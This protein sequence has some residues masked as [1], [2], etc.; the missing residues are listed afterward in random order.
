MN[1]VF[2]CDAS[3]EIG[4]GHVMRCLTLAKRLQKRGAICSFVC[5]DQAANMVELINAAG[6]D[7]VLLNLDSEANAQE[8]NKLFHSAWLGHSQKRDAELFCKLLDARD[9]QSDWVVVDHY[10]LD[11]DWENRVKNHFQGL[12][13]F[14]IDDL[15]DRSHDCDI[16]LD[17]NFSPD[18]LSR[19]GGKLPAHC[20]VFLGPKYFLLKEDF[21][22]FSGFPK[23]GTL[24]NGGSVFVFMGGLDAVNASVPIVEVLL[25]EWLQK[26]VRRI[27]IVVGRNY[28]Y[29]KQ[30]EQLADDQRLRVSVQLPSLH[31]MLMEAI[32]GIGAGGGNMYERCA[33]GLPC[34]VYAVAPNQ[35]EASKALADYGAITYAGDWADF[36]P[37]VLSKLLTEF[38]ENSENAVLMSEKCFSLKIGSSDVSQ[39]LWE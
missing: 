14:V 15:A 23:S 27:N 35:I 10:S 18:M 2:R 19:Y 6:F 29:K 28:S 39:F 30:L 26:F 8:V 13:I 32:L 7:C 3:F 37:E 25:S 20:K 31:P 22:S 38:F 24:Q 34:V 33:L 4:S 36:K 11:V 9:G 17:Q 12:R 16:L 1:V 21:K 5:V